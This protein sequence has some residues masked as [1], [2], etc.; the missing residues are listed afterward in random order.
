M[1]LAMQLAKMSFDTMMGSQW[2]TMVLVSV[3]PILLVRII[4]IM[5]NTVFY[6]VSVMDIPAINS[7]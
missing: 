5:L 4:Y 6:L 3:L 7:V 1:C 2:I